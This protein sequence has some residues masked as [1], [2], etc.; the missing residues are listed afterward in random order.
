MS[1][2]VRRQL[3]RAIRAA[4]V[5]SAAS[6]ASRINK[7]SFQRLNI[8][9]FAHGEV[10]RAQHHLAHGYTRRCFEIF[11][12]NQSAEKCGIRSRN[13][14]SGIVLSGAEARSLPPRSRMLSGRKSMRRPRS[15]ADLG[16]DSGWK[17]PDFIGVAL[18][19]KNRRLRAS[20]WGLR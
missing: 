8:E 15:R 17:K 12:T 19:S 13:G 2:I 1:V 3:E 20:W 14:T 9:W 5:R 7:V 6:G 10:R 11:I 18:N 16:M 4:R